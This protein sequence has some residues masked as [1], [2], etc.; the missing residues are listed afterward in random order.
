MSRELRCTQCHL[1]LTD[2]AALR[3]SPNIAQRCAQRCEAKNRRSSSLRA[4]DAEAIATNDQAARGKRRH[5]AQQSGKTPTSTESAQRSAAKAFGST[6]LKALA[7]TRVWSIVD[8]QCHK[9][10]TRPHK[11]TRPRPNIRAKPRTTKQHGKSARP[12]AFARK[13]H[14]SDSYP[15]SM[16]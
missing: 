1:C 16:Q 4:P 3:R 2:G 10:A 6:S 11:N 5:S 12:K 14:L 8:S 13:A 7:R 15:L 9:A